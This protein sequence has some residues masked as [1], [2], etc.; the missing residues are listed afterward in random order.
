MELAG[1]PHHSLDTYLPKLVPCRHARGH[2]RPVGRPEADEEDRQ[3]R[4]DGIRDAGRFSQRQ[5]P[6]AQKNNFLA[7]VHTDGKVWGV[8]FLNI[9]TG[10]F[11]VAEGKREYIDK[12]LQNFQPSES[13]FPAAPQRIT[14]QLG[15]RFYQYAVDEMGVPT[16]LCP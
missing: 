11:L 2:L 10:E 5:D 1:F 15:N 9:S 7:S 13:S 12:L 16:R 4:R 14:E 6:R 8:A 3:A